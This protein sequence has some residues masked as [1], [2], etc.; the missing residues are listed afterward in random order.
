MVPDAVSPIVALVFL[1]VT[2]GTWLIGRL[3]RA[4][5]ALCHAEALAA[6]RGRCLGLLARDLE[7]PAMSLLALSPLVPEPEGAAVDAAARRLLALADEASDTLAVPAHPRQLD[8]TRLP[9]GPLLRETLEEVGPG[10]AGR[11]WRLSPETEAV[12]LHAD[13]R[14]L[15]RVLFQAMARAVRETRPADWIAVRLAR[16]ED[17]LALIVED[18]G[19]GLPTGDLTGADGTRGVGLGLATA[20]DLMRAHGGDLVTETAPGI[21]GRTWLTLPSWRVL[22]TEASTA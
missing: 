21:G 10:G 12:V 15:K 3:R 17:T 13:G 8:P 1:A 5:T 6:S 7:G 18:E 4:E 20:R 22:D 11:R 2:A 9:L 16:T 14:A 19:A